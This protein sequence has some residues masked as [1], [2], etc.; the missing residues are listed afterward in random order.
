MRRIL[1]IFCALSLLAASA[2]AKEAAPAGDVDA[3]EATYRSANDITASFV[4]TTDIA[5]VGKTVTKRG[6]FAFKRG[7]KLRIEYAGRDGKHYVSD[8]TTL[9]TFIPGDE[10][11]L[12][13]FAVNDRTVPKEALSFLS[14]FGKLS[15]EFAVSESGVFSK[16]PTGATALHLVPR[17]KSAQYDALDALFGPDHLLSE[18]IVQNTSGNVSRYAFTNI[19]T[20]VGLSDDRFTLS[21]GKATPD[22]LPQ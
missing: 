16:V 13:T 14:G 4:Q 2:A 8:G 6:T 12:T 1:F 22:T 3:I 10:A 11:S 5:L 7:G 15:R 9:W 19:K 17:K 20:N 21:S 18:L